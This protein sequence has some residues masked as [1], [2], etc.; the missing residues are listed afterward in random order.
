MTKG[1][2]CN[3]T[4]HIIAQLNQ[5]HRPPFWVSFKVSFCD[6]FTLPFIERSLLLVLVT[7]LSVTEWSTCSRIRRE[8][9]TLPWF[10]SASATMG[11]RDFLGVLLLVDGVALPLGDFAF[12]LT[13][14]STSS[15]SSS[16]LSEATIDLRFFVSFGFEEPRDVLGVGWDAFLEA[17]LA[18][19]FAL[20][21]LGVEVVIRLG[22]FDR[23]RLVAVDFFLAADLL[24]WVETC[25]VATRD[26]VRLRV[27]RIAVETRK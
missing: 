20:V 14:K 26:G 23:A 2:V 24:F 21:G 13:W 6:W 11:D 3:V 27:L 8:R 4:L 22:V 15:S 9:R 19:V 16:S 7:D 25:G 17:D 5:P 1:S 10:G 18:G 12:L